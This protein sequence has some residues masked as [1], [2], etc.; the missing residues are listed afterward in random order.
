MAKREIMICCAHG[1]SSS[2]IAEKTSKAAKDKGF[3]AEVFA[4]PRSEIG[5]KL[6]TKKVDAILIGPSLRFQID[7]IKK[8]VSDSG[9][10][11]GV[12]VIGMQAY[13]MLDGEK[14]LTQ[15]EKIMK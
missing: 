15:A 2:L 3:D 7:N 9:Q 1:M 5:D 10:D 8:Q 13:G 6:K 4:V 12:D 14:I 11:T